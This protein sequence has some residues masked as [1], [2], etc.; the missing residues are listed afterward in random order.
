MDWD[1]F[2]LK[3]FGAERHRSMMLLFFLSI[4]AGL[5]SLVILLISLF[6]SGGV[7]GS[8]EAISVLFT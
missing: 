7:A 1:P 8:S 2:N 4:T 6:S 5:I 3:S